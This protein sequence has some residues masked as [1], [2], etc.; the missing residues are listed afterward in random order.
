MERRLLSNHRVDLAKR[1]VGSLASNQKGNEVN[2]LIDVEVVGQFVNDVAAFITDV[3]AHHELAP[4]YA[5]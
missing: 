4:Q 2:R 3:A 1:E 5:E